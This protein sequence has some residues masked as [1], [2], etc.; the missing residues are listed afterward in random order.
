M[1][2]ILMIAAASLALLAASCG[3]DKSKSATQEER[4][5]TVIAEESV[6]V[7][8]TGVSEAVAASGQTINPQLPTVVDFFA[9]WCGPCRQISPLVEQL[10]VK[11]S[12]KINFI[13]VDVDQASECAAHYD[14]Q[15]MPTFVFFSAEGREIDRLVG[16]DP[17]TLQQKVAGLVGN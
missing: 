13:Q 3:T 15:A 4:P 14:I 7:E 12:G 6:T 10:A 11:Y 8:G 2:K 17:E 9:T 1:R 5:E 16:A